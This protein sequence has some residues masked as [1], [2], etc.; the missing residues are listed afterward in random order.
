MPEP[1]GRAKEMHRDLVCSVDPAIIFYFAM[2]RKCME[3][4]K[5]KNYAHG[6]KIY[7]WAKYHKLFVITLNSDNDID[8]QLSP[9]LHIEYRALPGWRAFVIRAIVFCSILPG[10]AAKRE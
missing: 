7:R 10:G 2:C 6:L 5:A 3:N 8:K 1:D 4:I 9:L